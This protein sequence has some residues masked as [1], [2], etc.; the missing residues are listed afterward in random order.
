MALLNSSVDDE[1]QIPC[2]F[3]EYVELGRLKVLC[4]KSAKLESITDIVIGRKSIVDK[5]AVIRADLEKVTI[6]QYCYIGSRTILRPPPRLVDLGGD[7]DVALSQ[8]STS[9]SRG[10]DV[11]SAE[12][13]ACFA[14]TA[15]TIT[16]TK[17][18]NLGRIDI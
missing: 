2:V 5:E 14:A 11:S 18:A 10:S 3:P 16:A 9:R 17:Q 6:G 15:T 7:D 8:R 12:H 1:S 13:S 4:A